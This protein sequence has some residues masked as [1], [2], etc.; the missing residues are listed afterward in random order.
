MTLNKTLILIPT[1]NEAENV[2]AIFNEIHRLNLDADILFI[3]DHSPDGTGDIIDRLVGRYSHLSVIHRSGK[4]GIGSAHLEGIRWAYKNNYTIL[5]TMDCDF[6]H[7]PRYLSDFIRY[8][9]NY[10]IVIGSRYIEQGSLPG[11]NWY[12]KSLTYIGHYLISKILKMPYDATGAFRLYR[13]DKIPA[14]IFDM[15]ESRTYSFFFESLYILHRNGFRVKEFPIKLPNRTYG[16]SKMTLRLAAHSLTR[17]I[18]IYFKTLTHK[19]LFLYF[20]PQAFDSR[21]CSTSTEPTRLNTTQADWN[22][23]WS[24]NK[25]TTSRVYDLIAAFY[26]KFVIKRTLNH[27]VKKYFEGGS[28]ILHAGCGSG[29][30][31]RDVANWVN[32]SA[33]DISISALNIYRKHNMNVHKLIHGDISDIPVKN[34]SFDGIYSLGVMEHFSEEGIHKIL[35]EFHRVLKPKKKMIIFWAPELGLSVLFLKAVHYTLNNFFNKNIKLHPDEITRARSKEQVKSILAKA[36]LK[37]ID[38]YFGIKDFFTH[39]IIVIEKD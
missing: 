5:I 4:L 31:D 34:E 24:V 8:S 20:H 18:R 28:E 29:M 22:D 37:M 23:Y 10:D 7:S 9:T 21:G 36:D 25:R 1:Y 19:G 16:H 3:D 12:R 2:E 17:L 15:I 11:W 39:A 33:L 13:L 38:Y 26:R 6:S 27:F 32:L 14:G 30:V 35:R